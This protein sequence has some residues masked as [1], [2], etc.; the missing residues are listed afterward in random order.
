M[1]KE[2]KIMGTPDITYRDLEREAELNFDWDD[3]NKMG[4]WESGKWAYKNPEAQN[5]VNE[6]MKRQKLDVPYN[7]S[8][9]D[10]LAEIRS[11]KR[12]L[13]E[14]KQAERELK[15]QESHQLHCKYC[16]STNL[17]LAGDNKKKFSAGKSVAGAS[18]LGIATGGLGFIVGAGAGFAGKKGRKNVFVCLN[19]GKVTE[20]RK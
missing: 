4:I 2:N 17:Q 8:L 20:M 18:V 9:E 13:S 6:T 16:G 11:E 10:K 19:C 3:Y 14:K 12:D 15:Q 7:E 5:Y 1:R